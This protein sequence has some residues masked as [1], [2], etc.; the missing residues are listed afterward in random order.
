LTEIIIDK[1]YCGPPNSG[2]GGYVCGRLAQHIRGA[3]EV[4]LRAP[5]P[6]DTPLAAIATDDGTWELRDGGNVVA[7]ARAESVE[8]AQLETASFEE[9]RAAELLTPI[10]PHEHPLPTCFV[11]GPARTEGDGLRIFVGPLGRH[12]QRPVLAASWI[13]DSGLAAAD[14]R[15]ATEFLWSALDCPTGLP[16]IVIRRAA[17]STKRR[18]CWAECQ[19]GS[20]LAR[21]PATAASSPHG[22]PAA[23][24]AS[25]PPRPHFMMKAGS[26][27]RWRRRHGLQWNATCSS[28]ARRA[29]G[30]TERAIHRAPYVAD[31]KI[32]GRRGRDMNPVVTASRHQARSVPLESERR[33]SAKQISLAPQGQ[34]PQLLARTFLSA[35]PK[36]DR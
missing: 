27:S 1:R 2:N 13:P 20:S 32:S 4:T 11:C 3:A 14:G 15:I 28:V 25:A 6:L 8:L 19:H 30:R 9:A 23:T 12:T 16:A 22:P 5:P 35:Y 24:A 36:T 29:G 18:S 34:L 10:K 31:R 7:T 17:P 26:C 33:P 21:A